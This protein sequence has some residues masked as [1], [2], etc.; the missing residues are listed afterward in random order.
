MA[1]DYEF[2]IATDL[3]PLQALCLLADELGLVWADDS[4]LLGPALWLSAIEKS[5][6][7]KA[8]MEEAFGFRPTLSV[9]FRLN[10]NVSDEEYEE[11]KRT[12]IRA[13]ILL[14]RH[15]PGDAVLLF[16]GENV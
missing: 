3:G 9:G 2:E 7:G 15:E 16:N 4:H 8:V 14:L 5:A 1:L 11:G 12:M 10:P 13:T 6:L